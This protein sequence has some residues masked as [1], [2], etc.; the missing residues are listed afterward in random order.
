MSAGSEGAC[1]IAQGAASKETRRDI[2][3]VCT[4]R[5]RAGL[6]VRRPLPEVRDPVCAQPIS[7]CM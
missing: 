1:A 7:A 4:G 5:A 2:Q 6:G 3:I